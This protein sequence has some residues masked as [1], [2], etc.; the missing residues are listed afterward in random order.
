MLAVIGA[1]YAATISSLMYYVLVY[2][3][4]NM[5][6]FAI[7][8]VVEQ[9]NGGRTDME[10]YNGFYQTNPK[11]SFL[12]TLALFSLGTVVSLY[13]YLLIVK[14]MYINKTDNPLPTFK[15]DCNTRLTLAICTAGILLFGIA[16]CIYEAI[17]AAAAA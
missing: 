17:H 15:S 3:V 5:S 14:A 11:L 9:N 12:M 7:I 13:Y 6:V 8:S 10:A 2:I 16:S 4:A 1:D